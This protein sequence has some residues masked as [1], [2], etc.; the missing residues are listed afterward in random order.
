MPTWRRLH[1]PAAQEERGFTLI[2]MVVTLTIIGGVFLSLS[3][4]MFGSL[5]AL[6]ASRQR[7]IFTD[8]A[9]KEM[10]SL[11]SLPYED[12]GVRS[13][14]LTTYSGTPPQ[15]DGRDAV[16][17]DVVA[18]PATL[19]PPAVSVVTTSTIQGITLPYTV[20][21]WVTWTDPD[22]STGHKF[23]RL[24]IEVTWSENG[25][26]TRQVD[27]ASVLFP[28][29]LGTNADNTNPTADFTFSPSTGI[30][31]GSTA[32]TFSASASD[33]DAGASFSYLW[34]FGD[35]GT[36]SGATVTHTFSAPGNPWSVVMVASDGQG[37]SHVVTKPVTVSAVAN[38]PPYGA[39]FTVTP[40]TGEGPLTVT[41]DASASDD[42]DAQTDLTYHWDFGD[43]TVLSTSSD[44]VPHTYPAVNAVTAYTVS[45]TVTDP[46]GGASTATAQ[47]VT[48]EPG[49][50][51]ITSASFQQQNNTATNNVKVQSN[52]KPRSSEKSFTF[53]VRTS[54]ECL[55]VAGRLPLAGG[56]VLGGASGVIL[57][58]TGGA[59]SGYQDW[60]GSGTLSGS[61]AFDLTNGAR[62]TWDAWSPASTGA[63]AASPAFTVT[64]G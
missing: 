48:V 21:R 6:G 44:A 57:G 33:P 41:V 1:R 5:R 46:G 3:F 55:S 30:V 51:T 14:D 4:V 23:K 34:N 22:A 11:R 40:N 43:G 10:E 54:D 24:H 27:L 9:N 17:I 63:I 29:N 49:P 58:T 26:S 15:H 13:D 38:T 45:L 25:R 60:R 59:P 39:S 28:G 8:L 36:A 19:A 20:R 50:C 64:V 62:R 53:S 35:G 31:E 47:T 12:V 56:T 42:D 18:N 52:G 37:G 61:E 32:V 2:E 7:S 16:I